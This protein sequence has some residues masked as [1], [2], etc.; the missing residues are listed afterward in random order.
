MIVLQPDT[1]L[2]RAVK[3]QQRL[4]DTMSHEIMAPPE[5]TE[6]ASIEVDKEFSNLEG[7]AIYTVFHYINN[8][9]ETFREWYIAVRNDGKVVKVLE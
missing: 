1:V 9:P 7:D 4:A 2:P 6:L 8:D 3:R 5:Q